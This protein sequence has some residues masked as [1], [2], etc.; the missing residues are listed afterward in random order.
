[1]ALKHFRF[2][3]SRVE[4]FKP[5]E[6]AIVEVEAMH[7]S[8]KTTDDVMQRISNAVA[9]WIENDKEAADKFDENAGEMNIIDIADF[10]DELQMYLVPQG[11]KNLGIILDNDMDE[12]PKNFTMDTN[13]PNRAPEFK[14]PTA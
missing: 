1:M 9:A 7:D 2:K 11:L 10:T 14:D 3:L 12:D 13:L 8:I 5:S 6:F 4:A